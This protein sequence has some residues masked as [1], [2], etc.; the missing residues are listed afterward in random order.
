VLTAIPL[1]NSPPQPAGPRLDFVACGQGDPAG[2]PYAQL[3]SR[4][5]RE[6]VPFSALLEL[7]HV[8]NL[9]CVM[10]YNVPLDQPEL[11]TAEWLDALEQLAAAG[12][13]RLTLSG[14]EILTRRDFFTIAGRARTL[15]FALDLKTNGTLITPES[16]DR[17]AALQPL[18]VDISL[19]GATEATFDA[20]AGSKNTLTR[21]LRGV[22]LLQERGVWVRLNTL[23]LDLNVAERNLMLDL[24]RELG[25]QYEQV[26]KVSANDAGQD[27]AGQHQLSTREIAAVMVG[28]NGSFQRRVPL[29]ETRTCQVGLSSCVI[30]PYGEVYPCIELRMPAGNLRRASFA[31]IW[32]APV[33]QELRSR[34][35]YG[36]LP[37]CRICPINAYCEGRCAGLAW[38]QDGNLYG[39][40]LAACLQAQARYEQQHPG[41]AAP[42]T[43]LQVK[44]SNGNVVA[45]T[46]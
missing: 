38:K 2:D 28:D 6:Y 23:L 37:E 17:I 40:D 12:T 18:Q 39:A 5:R 21:V 11:S 4:L 34:H 26:V 14:G 46:A 32:Q 29:A 33:F 9:D 20:V 35:T 42:R 41:Q 1:F 7:T 25:V 8:C 27:K 15:G 10:C 13:L 3:L 31:S 45:M 19:L 22:R 36:N 16:A 30:S 44:R 43:P 24:V